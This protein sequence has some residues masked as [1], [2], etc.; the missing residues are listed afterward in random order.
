M[1]PLGL[2]T[3]N[4]CVGEAQQQFTQPHH[5][6]MRGGVHRQQGVLVSLILFYFV[7]FLKVGKKTRN[8]FLFQYFLLLSVFVHEMHKEALSQT[9]C[10]K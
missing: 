8:I 7:F 3:R 1:S 6:G 4:N 5:S 10:Y 9:D 2:G